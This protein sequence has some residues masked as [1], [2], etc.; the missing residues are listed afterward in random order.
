MCVPPS[1][2]NAETTCARRDGG[3]KLV[4]NV[5]GSG[6]GVLELS[7]RFAVGAFAACLSV[8]QCRRKCVPRQSTASAFGVERRWFHRYSVSGQES[9]M[10][11]TALVRPGVVIVARTCKSKYVSTSS[12]L[13]AGEQLSSLGKRAVERSLWLCI[14]RLTTLTRCC[15]CAKSDVPAQEW[16][17]Y[18]TSPKEVSPEGGAGTG[19]TAL[20]GKSGQQTEL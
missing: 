6:D 5:A 16:W 11:A 8:F 19:K 14:V 4:E 10:R 1:C 18:V 20:S 2:A 3:V 7:G 17:T 12:L 15:S 13:F 9:V